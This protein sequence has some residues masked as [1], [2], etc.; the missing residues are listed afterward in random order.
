MLRSSADLPTI[1]DGPPHPHVLN[2]RNGM[3]DWETGGFADWHDPNWFSTVQLGVDWNPAATCPRYDRWIKQ[4]LPEDC[5]DFIDEVTGY[6]MLSG[7]PLHKAFLLKGSGRNG[8]GTF[9]RIHTALLGQEN[10]ASVPLQTMGENGFAVA[11]LHMKLANVAGDLDN[12]HVEQTNVFK[13]VTGQ[14]ECY[15]ERKNQQPFRFTAWA[16]PIFSANQI[17]TTSDTSQGYLSR[18]EVIPFPLDLR[19]VGID[20]TIEKDIVTRAGGDRGA[21]R[22]RAAP[23]DGAPAVRT[24]RHGTGRVLE[25]R[26]ARGPGARVDRRPV[27]HVGR[28][29]VDLPHRPAPGLQ[30]VGR[31]QRSQAA[32]GRDI[33]RASRNGWVPAAG[34]QEDAGFVGIRLVNPSAPTPVWPQGTQARI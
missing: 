13:V 31:G 28:V 15:A 26:A 12:R 33:L 32:G 27:R 30:G 16:V 10:C 18:W 19:Q 29:G 23:A 20:P 14:D 9:L 5:G 3:L 2:F 34:A 17:P 11:N 8:K 24:A 4:V 6:L 1:D 7:N 21:R 22:A 25:L